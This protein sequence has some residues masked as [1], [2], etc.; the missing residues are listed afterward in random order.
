MHTCEAAYCDIPLH[1]IDCDTLQQLQQ[2]YTSARHHTY[3]DTPERYSML[4]CVAVGHSALQCVAVFCSVL[5][6]VAVR[7]VRQHTYANTLGRC[8]MLQC[9]AVG[10]SAV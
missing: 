2:P 10:H 6:Y 9:V 4:Q 7:P 3:E 8:S 1:T 5:Q